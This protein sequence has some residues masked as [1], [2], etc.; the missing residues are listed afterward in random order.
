MLPSAQGAAR[1]WSC[2]S[3][4]AG[5][6]GVSPPT[7]WGI[8]M[9]A[10]LGLEVLEVCSWDLLLLVAQ[11]VNSGGIVPWSPQQHVFIDS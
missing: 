10:E 2:G 4:Q 1:G 6:S 8:S 9:W 11:G 5:W 7:T 3:A